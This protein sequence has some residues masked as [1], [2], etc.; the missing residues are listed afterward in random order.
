MIIIPK[1]INGVCL[2]Y[3]FEIWDRFSTEKSSSIIQISE[4]GLTFIH[5]KKQI[6]GHKC[7]FG[8]ELIESLDNKMIYSWTFKIISCNKFHFPIGICP[9]N[10]YSIN[11]AGL[12]F[13]P[14]KNSYFYDALVDALKHQ[15]DCI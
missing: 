2:E 4:D 7:V 14:L 6:Y 1:E 5:S 9:D 11:D 10:D 12:V 3:L 13:E 15:R 8:E